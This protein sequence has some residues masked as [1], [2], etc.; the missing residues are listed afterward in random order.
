MIGFHRTHK[1]QA[2]FPLVPY[3]QHLA[4]GKLF[5]GN[6]DHHVL[7]IL[8]LPFAVA[9]IDGDIVGGHRFHALGGIGV[10]RNSCH[11]GVIGHFTG[12]GKVHVR[13]VV[14]QDIVRGSHHARGCDS[15]GCRLAARRVSCE[16]RQ[17]S[18]RHKEERKPKERH[19]TRAPGEM[20]AHVLVRAVVV[21]HQAV[22]NLISNC[23]I[24]HDVIILILY[25]YYL[26][27]SPSRVRG[28]FRPIVQIFRI[29]CLR[30]RFFARL[31]TRANRSKN[32]TKYLSTA[33]C[34]AT[35]HTDTICAPIVTQNTNIAY[36]LTLRT[37][38]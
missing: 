15:G 18:T 5:V 28:P 4:V 36:F 21:F 1:L 24:C 11:A 30:T 8:G 27:F 9:L 13:A 20:F 10:H 38:Y 23:R 37:S 17:R 7:A 25:F 33:F 32:F 6:R 12:H 35:E 22:Y 14:G 34:K 16:G 3:I 31:H 2:V 19:K 29:F 26:L